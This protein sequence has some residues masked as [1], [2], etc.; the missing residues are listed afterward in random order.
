MQ[1]QRDRYL[2]AVA[3]R[4]SIHV[5]SL[6]ADRRVDDDHPDDGHPEDETQVIEG[7]LS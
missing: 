7:A 4:R 6:V 2:R 3:R 5:P 1:R